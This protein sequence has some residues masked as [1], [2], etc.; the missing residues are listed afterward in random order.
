MN[1]QPVL[2]RS[3]RGDV[4]S[5]RSVARHL[6]ALVCL[7]A[8]ATS[9]QQTVTLQPL[10]P[11]IVTGA[12]V[13]H[14][15][16][17]TLPIAVVFAGGNA[18]VDFAASGLPTGAT[19]NFSTN[20]ITNSQTINLLVNVAGIAKGVYPV[21]INASGGASASATIDLIAG[22]FWIA[23]NL[24]NVNWTV[25]TNWSSGLV[26]TAGDHVKF[27]DGGVRTNIVDTSVSIDSLTYARFI[28]GS[29][30]T[31]V[32]PAGRT[33]SVVG[34]GGFSANVES[35][36]GNNKQVNINIA[37][38]GTLAV[39]NENANFT[40]N[41]L[42]TGGSGTTLDMSGL[43][44]FT[45]TV[46]RFGIGDVTL[47]QAGSVGAQLV[48]VSLA[49]TNVIRAG[50][51]EPYTG[52][53]I[54][55]SI[56]IFH[57]G[58]DFNNGSANTFNLGIVNQFFADSFV[59][60][61]A[62][63]G[64]ANNTVRFN[65]AFLNSSPSA[66]FRNTNGGRMTLFG[67]TVDDGENAP[68]SNSRLTANFNGGVL[69]LLAEQMWIGRNRF[70]NTSA[71]RAEGVLTFNNGVVDVNTLRLGYQAYT[72]DM[73]ARGIV[74]VGGPGVLVVNDEL[75]LGYTSGDYTAGSA[76]MGFGQI[77]ITNNGVARVNRIR[78]GQQSG[79]NF[80]RLNSGGNLILTNTIAS[81]AKP[82]GELGMSDAALTVHL[83]S[84]ATNVFVTNLVCG[85]LQNVI[86]VASVTV[87]SPYPA[88]IAAI[89][90]QNTPA[91]PNIAMGS[92]PPGLFGF[93][94]N[95]TANKTIDV[96]INTN[97]PKTVIWRGNVNGNWDT[98][99]TNWVDANTLAATTFANGDFAV[100]DDSGISTT[101]TL[102]GNLLPGQSPTVSGV[103][104]SNTALHYNFAG[105][106]RIVGAT[107]TIKQGS[108]SLTIGA[109]TESPILV[110]AGTLTGNGDIGAVTVAL[111]AALT[112]SGDINGP[113]V[114]GGTASSSGTLTGSLTVQ[115]G[116][117][118]MNSGTLS[119]AVT[120]Q[121]NATLTNTSSGI[122]NVAAAWNIPSGARVVNLG[123]IVQAGRLDVNAGGTL[124]GTG[125]FE[126]AAGV[127]GDN[128]RV[129]VNSGGTF[130]PGNGDIGTLT[131]NTRFDMNAGSTN[132]FEVDLTAGTKDVA[133]ADTINFAGQIRI[134]NV[135]TTAFASGQSFQILVPNFPPNIPNNA[136]VSPFIPSVPGPGMVWLTNTAPN[137]I[138]T[139]GFVGIFQLTSGTPTNISYS[140][141]GGVSTISWPA[142]HLGW[143]LQG[144]TNAP[145]VGL[146]TNWFTVAGSTTNTTANVTNNPAMG[147]SF[148]RLTYP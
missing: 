133:A 92:L 118:F 106:G 52:L 42:N 99:T 58:Q 103:T 68:G 93:V 62:R 77:T 147:S 17:Y 127:S 50:F 24:N 108:A 75:E 47:A 117:V 56:Q 37:G 139:N 72:N 134:V 104:I 138:R 14:T 3:S 112:F 89:S 120:L 116:S 70:T 13:T 121:A 80:V 98:T 23:T 30:H 16:T 66:V 140:L 97:A 27:E 5:P 119:G 18:A 85:G 148:F 41:A 29:N 86:N 35:F 146:G 101:V 143:R 7:G 11:K 45:A 10:L 79:A 33:L 4:L 102:V 15:N 34:T 63:V 129:A 60:A 71:A 53:R 110:S 84:G 94:E 26:T 28:S 8:F 67:I 6:V 88:R 19:A 38:G 100:F 131:M 83:T 57:N 82:L 76:A 111:G 44:N 81:A 90:Y 64:S 128:S 46:S 69:D 141:A 96:V 145:G 136:N 144:Q 113:V 48:V 142:S 73:N 43:S 65:P 115:S 123:N 54:T 137:F 78:V 49:R 36:V 51:A 40:V 32:I 130:S 107:R 61:R 126:A 132:I 87:G 31:T 2:T 9:A 91:L 22:Q 39:S 59:A 135:G 74:F 25:A 105:A 124:Q 21:A 95:N 125:L 109:A 20:S 122:M 12:N 55:N 1:N 114:S